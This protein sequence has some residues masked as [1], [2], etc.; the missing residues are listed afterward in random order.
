MAYIVR[1]YPVEQRGGA[2]GIL[3][4][5][6]AAGS[7]AGPATGGVLFERVGYSATFVL[8]LSCVLVLALSSAKTLPEVQTSRGG[9]NSFRALLR[10][11]QVR[12][13]VLCAA[14]SMGVLGMFEAVVPLHMQRSFGTGPTAIGLVFFGAALG[15]GLASPLAGFVA[16]HRGTR[17]TMLAGLTLLSITMVS[18]SVSGSVSM[19]AISLGV[20][21]VASAFALVPVLPRMAELGG[22]TCKTNDSTAYALLNFALDT[23]IMAGPLLGGLLMS[24][25]GFTISI[26]IA[27]VILLAGAWLSHI[28]AG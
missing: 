26:L 13:L 5:G 1:I 21:G 10:R 22:A 24:V 7:I 20:A 11:P 18:V 16:D 3:A 15:Q 25:L 2:M 17:F 27:A 28:K 6:F 19:V 4:G 8:I 12:L 9:K 14:L 23:G